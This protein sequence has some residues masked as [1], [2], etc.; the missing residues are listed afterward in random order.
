MSKSIQLWPLYELIEIPTQTAIDPV[1][2]R[3]SSDFNENQPM[4]GRKMFYFSTLFAG[5]QIIST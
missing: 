4:K 1:W 2:E 3:A 5:T